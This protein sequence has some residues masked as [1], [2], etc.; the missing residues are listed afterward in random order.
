MF[1]ADLG[2]Q[3]CYDIPRTF[4]SDKSCSFDFN[5]SFNSYLVSLSTTCSRISFKTISIKDL[6]HRY[7]SFQVLD[8]YDYGVLKCTKVQIKMRKLAC[9]HYF[10]CVC[11]FVLCLSMPSCSLPLSLHPL[12]SRKTKAWC[13]WAASPWRKLTRTT[14]PWAPTPRPTT[15]PAACRAVNPSWNPTMSPW[16]RARAP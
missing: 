9:S 13:Q 12:P 10:S 6:S 7:W 16:P 2:S 4:P 8:C 15:A 3:D 14:Y 11:V 1:V 5:E